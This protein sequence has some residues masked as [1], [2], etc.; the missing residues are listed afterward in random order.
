MLIKFPITDLGAE[1]GH[2]EGWM[3]KLTDMTN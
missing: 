1:F 2:L 3:E